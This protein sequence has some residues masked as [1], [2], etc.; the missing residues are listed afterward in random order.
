MKRYKSAVNLKN[1][2]IKESQNDLLFL[3]YGGEPIRISRATFKSLVKN[4]DGYIVG[5]KEI[6]MHIDNM[7][8]TPYRAKDFVESVFGLKFDCYLLEI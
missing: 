5:G 1:E 8:V 4:D 3:H 2:M 6:K 7:E